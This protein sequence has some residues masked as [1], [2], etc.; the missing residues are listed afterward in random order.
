MARGPQAVNLETGYHRAEFLLQA[1]LHQFPRRGGSIMA[2]RIRVI[3]EKDCMEVPAAAQE[4][5]DVA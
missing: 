1:R 2:S 5:S 3:A 4:W